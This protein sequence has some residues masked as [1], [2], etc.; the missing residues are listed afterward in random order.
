M[1]T[2]IL[3]AGACTKCG[4]RSQDLFGAR[5]FP[6][7]FSAS[8]DVEEVLLRRFCGDLDEIRWNPLEVLASSGTAPWKERSWWNPRTGPCMI[9]NP[10]QV[11]VRRSCISLWEDLV[12]VLDRRSCRDPDE[13]LQQPNRSL[14]VDLV[15]QVK[16]WS[17]D[18]MLLLVT[19]EIPAAVEKC[20]DLLYP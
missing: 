17:L 6:W 3:T 13:I 14:W 12:K 16:S 20:L 9:L 2:R 5:Y 4:R 10:V 11:L 7:E 15:D 1:P 8:W 19:K 18:I